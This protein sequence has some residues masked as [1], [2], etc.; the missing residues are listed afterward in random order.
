MAKNAFSKALQSLVKSLA[1]GDATMRAYWATKYI[2]MDDTRRSP[3]PDD[4]EFANLRRLSWGYG[5][6]AEAWKQMA[7]SVHLKDSKK[8]KMV[9]GVSI[10]P[11]SAPGATGE[12]PVHL[13]QCLN[14]RHQ[15]AKKTVPEGC[16]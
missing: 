15:G 11:N 5:N 1:N 2:P 16:R 3:H 14:Q 4:I 6:S 13:E 9:P 12:R 7:N 8:P 10:N